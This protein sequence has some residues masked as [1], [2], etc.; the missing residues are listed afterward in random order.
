M[1]SPHSVPPLFAYHHD[2][3]IWHGTINAFFQEWGK[4]DEIRE[5]K[6]SVQTLWKFRTVFHKM[7]ALET[8]IRVTWI[9]MK[10]TD[11]WTLPLTHWNGI[12]LYAMFEKHWLQVW[13]W[14]ALKNPTTIIPKWWMWYSFKGKFKIL[15]N[16][17]KY[18]MPGMSAW[19]LTI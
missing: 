4:G 14:N 9:F 5:S 12:F 3:N 13:H 6:V 15:Q 11:S 7:C 17:S 16:P 10:Y 18:M 19:I 2:P 8:C 1:W